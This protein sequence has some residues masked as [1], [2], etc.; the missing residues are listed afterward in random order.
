MDVRRFTSQRRAFVCGGIAALL[1]GCAGGSMS[2]MLPTASEAQPALEARQAATTQA[3]GKVEFTI[4]WPQKKTRIVTSR[5]P[6]FISPSTASVVIEV[7][8]PGGSTTF[9]NAPGKGGSSS[10]TLTAPE[11]RDSFVLTLYD[12]PQKA[13]ERMPAGNPLGT[14][15]VSKM[16]V[17]GKTNI[18]N[19]TIAGIVA[20]VT[21]APQPHQPF[22][23]PTAGGYIIAGDSPQKFVVTAVDADGNV[24]VPQPTVSLKAPSAGGQTPNLTA[25]YLA[26]K[27]VSKNVFAVNATSWNDPR[28]LIPLSLDG[29][30]QDAN[31]NSASASIGV[32]LTSAIYIGYANA[33]SSGAPIAVYDGSGRPL[34]LPSGAFAGTV[35]PTGLA[36][37]SVKHRLIVADSGVGTLLA[38]DAQGNIDRSFAPLRPLGLIS[39]IFDSNNA[40]LYSLG[41]QGGTTQVNAY[42]LNGTYVQLLYNYMFNTNAGSAIGFLNWPGIPNVVPGDTRIA[43]GSSTSGNVDIYSEDGTYQNT[44]SVPLAATTGL[45]GFPLLSDMVAVIGKPQTPS[46]PD[47]FMQFFEF[48]NPQVSLSIADPRAIAFDFNTD[49]LLVA[50]GSGNTILPISTSDASGLAASVGSPIITTP[51]SSGLSVPQALGVSY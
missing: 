20:N 2:R 35:D 39:V 31:G 7:D 18:L 51:A 44:A 37:D 24:I 3:T 49:N 14:A 33:G 30:A 8:P 26:V 29:S 23:E 46:G 48:G 21:I 42:Q 25:N 27:R 22:V 36:Y 15:T 41:S 6:R 40:L 19:A 4:R 1:A 50:S 28:G 34:P 13:R 47:F 9:A 16:I 45:T 43:L 5:G 32:T 17:A 10:I 12:Q 11:G 38:Y